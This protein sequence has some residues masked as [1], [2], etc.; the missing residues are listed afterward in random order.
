MKE[1]SELYRSIDE[2]TKTSAKLAAMQA[3]FLK[4][5]HEDAAWAVF[6]LSGERLKRLI[7]TRILREWAVRSSGT[8]EWLFEE[9]YSWVGDLAETIALLVPS[10]AIDTHGGLAF[11]VNQKIES[12][13]T[14]SPDRIHNELTICWQSIGPAE[15]FLFL[16]LVTGGLRVGVSKRLVTRAIADAFQLPTELVAHRLTG[17]WNPTAVSFRSLIANATDL[18]LPSQPYPFCLANSID[19]DPNSIGRTDEFLAEWKW[20]GIRS[21]L[22]KRSS[23]LY[24]WTRGEERVEERYPDIC[25]LAQHLPDGTVL[26]GEILA[27]QNNA[28]RPFSELQK[29]LGRKTISPKLLREIPVVFMAYDLLEYRGRD[30]RSEP[31]SKRR[32]WLSEV[33]EKT[34]IRLSEPISR[35]ELTGEPNWSELALIRKSSRSQGAEGLMLKRWDSPY[36]VGRVRGAWWKWKIEPL[37]IDAVLVYAQKGHGKRS[38]LF[39]DYTFAL[40][41]QGRLVPFAK[42]YS[43]LSDSEIR[44]VDEIIRANVKEKFVP[45]RG[46][47]PVLV[48]ELAF[49][50]IQLSSRHKSGFAVRFPRIERW[51]RDKLVRD[52]N[53]LDD[54]RD[55][56]RTHGMQVQS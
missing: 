14:A 49:E 50:N 3:F 52:A 16:K 45:V 47:T 56:I 15:R 20:D 53:S 24:I 17:T 33:L 35:S 54:L 5:S 26:D 46:V 7:N 4:A 22:I 13:K 29:R 40:W 30:V 43:G 11:W 27:W 48:M 31:L 51:R 6:F 23:E 44:E 42:A 2:T 10:Q 32:T 25:S 34:Q 41:D 19:G 18:M 9:S 1:F 28:P 55:L 39:T 37:T 12:L 38:S 8:S 36:Q 21:Q